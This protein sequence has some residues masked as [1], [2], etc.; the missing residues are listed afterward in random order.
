MTNNTTF[1][2]SN[3]YLPLQTNINNLGDY[4]GKQG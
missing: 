3:F 4:A 2:V 1:S